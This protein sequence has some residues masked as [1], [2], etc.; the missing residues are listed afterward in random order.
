[1]KV[2]LHTASLLVDFKG[3]GDIGLA[4]DDERPDANGQTNNAAKSAKV[5]HRYDRRHKRKGSHL[6]AHHLNSAEN[7]YGI[8]DQ[9]EALKN[10]S[11][12]TI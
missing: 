9:K 4:E 7:D 10:Q 1:M 5:Q 3:P 11:R 8:D 12:R 6:Y 2:T